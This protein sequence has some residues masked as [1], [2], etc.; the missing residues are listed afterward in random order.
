MENRKKPILRILAGFAAAVLI[1]GMLFITNSFVGNPI[2]AMLANKVIKQ[3]VDQNY[4]SLDL[5]IEKASYNFK[6]G[7]YM[8]R[9]KSKTSI[10]T[11]FA[12]YYRDGKVQRD[13]YESYVLGMFNT[14]QRFSEEYSA[15]AKNIIAKELGYLN[16]KT[17]VMV[18]KEIYENPGDIVELDMKFDKTLPIRA[19][20][21]LQLDLA[22]HSIEGIAKVLTDAHKAFAENDCYFDQYGLYAENDGMLIMISGVTPADIESGELAGLLEAA[23]ANDSAS[24]I[25]VFIKEQ[26]K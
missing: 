3:Y 24:G 21:T 22:D 1:A 8:A 12:V 4:S 2:S 20:V 16:N 13:D 11:K 26:K 9:V 25:G 14:L 19:E 10:D 7:A 23:K 5:E 6:D 15:V 18:H 17:M